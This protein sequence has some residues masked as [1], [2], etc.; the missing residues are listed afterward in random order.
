MTPINPGITF[1]LS[2]ESTSLVVLVDTSLAPG[3][4]YETVTAT[5]S[6]GETG[7]KVV[8][9]TINDTLTIISGTDIETTRGISRSSTAFTSG[10]GTG[11]KTFT[12]ASVVDSS[13]ATRSATDLAISV[14]S[15]GVVT[16]GTVALADT[17]TAI[18][19][20]TDAAGATAD[21]TIVIRVNVVVSVTGDSATLV[22]TATRADTTAAFVATGGTGNKTC[23]HHNQLTLRS[24]LSLGSDCRWFICDDSESD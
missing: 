10:S 8:T 13:G 11:A 17:Y 21:D 19:R 24:G 14:S 1:T 22:T 3:T 15:S 9:I 18:I 23:W 6:L 12:V 7:T 16:I 5:D 4:Y 20:V 2:N